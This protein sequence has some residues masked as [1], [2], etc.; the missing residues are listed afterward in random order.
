MDVCLLLPVF[1]VAQIPACS[2]HHRG[3]TLR[4][5]PARMLLSNYVVFKWI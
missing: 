1:S 3:T 4:T 2:R 5:M